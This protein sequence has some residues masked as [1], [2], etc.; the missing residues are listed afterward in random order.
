MSSSS[1]LVS[2]LAAFIPDTERVRAILSPKPDE[3]K[4]PKRFIKEGAVKFQDGKHAPK[5]AYFFLFNNVL[6]VTQEVKAK[7]KYKITL[8][9]TIRTTLKV[10]DVEDAADSD[11][12]ANSNV[13]V[14]DAVK[15]KFQIHCASSEEKDEWKQEIGAAIEGEYDLDVIKPQFTSVDGESIWNVRASLTEDQL[16]VL[17]EFHQR[18]DSRS[19]PLSDYAKE[20]I[21]DACLCR[22]LRARQ[23]NINDAFEM[24][25]ATITWR[26]EVRPDR[27]QHDDVN[28]AAATGDLYLA[29]MKDKKGRLMVYMRPGKSPDSPLVRAQYVLYMAWLMETAAKEVDTKHTAQE[30]MTWIVD[31]GNSK[32]QGGFEENIKLSRDVINVM[33]NHYPERLGMGFI[34]NPPL[35][36]YALWKILSAFVDPNTNRKIHFLRNKK[37]FHIL[38]QYIAPDQLEAPYGGTNDFVYSAEYWKQKYY[39]DA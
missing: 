6:F 23:W 12:D 9:V 3:L 28:H 14:I 15:K 22:Y 27:I 21:D 4:T 13:F 30:K 29:P 26:E 7:E 17:D 25:S 11:S 18:L 39:P 19:P 35:P 34:L 10:E 37:S 5:D 20:W 1:L 24:I 38:Q 32:I 33:Q 16:R 36:F 2:D 8:A 31:F